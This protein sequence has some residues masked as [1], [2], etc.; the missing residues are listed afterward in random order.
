MDIF[1]VAF[2]AHSGYIPEKIFF[3]TAYL[4][5]RAF[6]SFFY[7]SYVIVITETWFLASNTWVKKVLLLL[8]ITIVSG[9]IIS[10]LVTGKVFYLDENT[11][12]TRGDSFFWL[13]IFNAYYV[14][15]G[16]WNLNAFF[17]CLQA[18]ALS[19]QLLPPSIIC[20]TCL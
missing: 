11:N 10:N 20:R 7:L 9:F 17:Q 19:L 16:I 4:L 1:A 3:H 15:Y 5:L 13:Y 14:L 12:Y 6:T 8:P 2:D 18:W